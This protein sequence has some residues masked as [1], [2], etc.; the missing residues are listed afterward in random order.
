MVCSSQRRQDAPTDS[1]N[2]RQRAAAAGAAALLTAQALLLPLDALAAG[3]P[4][5]AAALEQQ[6][7]QQPPAQ[8]TLDILQQLPPLPTTF[9]PLPALALPK[10]KQVR[11]CGLGRSCLCQ[12]AYLSPPL[13][14][15]TCR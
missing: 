12:P 11:Q 2:W 10:Y 8:L 1:T 15:H 4:V 5:P 6:R 14:T 7:A 3:S 9:P 13:S